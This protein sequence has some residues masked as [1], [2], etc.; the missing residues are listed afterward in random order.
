MSGDWNGP[1]V[2]DPPGGGKLPLP[3]LRHDE[4]VLR[5]AGDGSAAGSGE[6]PRELGALARAVAVRFPDLTGK[7]PRE[8]VEAIIDHIA[9]TAI[10]RGELEELRLEAHVDLRAAIAE[11]TR[12]P[13]GVT[14]SAAAIMEAKRQARPD[15][16]ARADMAR[17]LVERATEQINRMGGTEYDAASRTYTL[18]VGS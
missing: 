14:R 18:L 12:V 3:E 17:W 9:E 1:Q 4:R 2:D 11:L 16:A 10:V 13:T 6:G 8:R 5:G 7:Q 15:L